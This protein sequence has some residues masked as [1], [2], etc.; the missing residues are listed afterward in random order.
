V[1]VCARVRARVRVCV[2]VS[3][4]SS[5]SDWGK[6]KRGVPQESKRAALSVIAQQMPS[7]MHVWCAHSTDYI[8]VQI[9]NHQEE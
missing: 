1:C 6:I 2:C 9:Y 7:H 5:S 3:H 4:H 8:T